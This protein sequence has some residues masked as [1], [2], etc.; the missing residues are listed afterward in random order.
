[1][2]CSTAESRG[3]RRTQ[4]RAKR[5]ARLGWQAASPESAERI[6]RLAREADELAELLGEDHDLVLLRTRIRS[7]EQ[8]HGGRSRP[9]PRTRKAL[10]KQIAQRRRRL[11]KRALQRGARLYRR[12]PKRFV[13]YLADAFEHV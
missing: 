6:R 7:R 12:S 8:A 9:G 2:R 4:A 3:G 13:R 5:N 1:M 11:R 10:L